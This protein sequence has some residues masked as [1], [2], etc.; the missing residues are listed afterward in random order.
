VPGI[1]D[2]QGQRV[3]RVKK[4]NVVYYYARGGSAHLKFAIVNEVLRKTTLG[5]CRVTRSRRNRKLKVSS[6][7]VILY[8]NERI[9]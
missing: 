5:A 9:K 2:L 8:P 3:C 1:T 4:K 7:I 6:K